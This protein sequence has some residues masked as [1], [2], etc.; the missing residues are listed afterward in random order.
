[1]KFTESMLN[2]Y[3]QPLSQT[4]DQQC[5]NAIN[6][7]VNAL[8]PLGFKEKRIKVEPMYTDTYSYYQELESEYGSRRIKVFMQGSYANNTNVRTQSDVDIAVVEEDIF[9]TQYRVGVSDSDYGFTKAATRPKSFKDEVEDALKESFGSDVQRANKSIKINGNTYRKDADGVPCRRYKNY[10][11]DYNNNPENFTGGIVITADTGERIINYPEQHIKNG[12]EKNVAT[13]YYYKK[14]VRI[15]KKMRYLM[16]EN[17]INEANGVSSFALE[18][19]LWNIP[20]DKYLEYKD[21][22]NVFM[23]DMLITHLKNN[24]HL[25]SS[26]KEANGIKLLCPTPSDINN[27][28]L[29][30]NALKEFYEY[31]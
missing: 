28:D 15:M 22:R 12:K 20:N 17:G 29:F 9:Q 4:E 8:K 27:M 11:N 14:M 2:S 1:M 31:E 5:K 19:L 16:K 10:S 24:K 21:F 25:L 6:M 3:A 30:I 18:S 7:V 23:F 13:N 26:Y